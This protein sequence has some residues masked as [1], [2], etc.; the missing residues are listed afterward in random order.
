MEWVN[1]PDVVDALTGAPID[2]SKS[3]WVCMT[4]MCRYQ[5]D[6]MA[7]IRE[8]NAGACISCGSM[9]FQTEEQEMTNEQ[10]IAEMDAQSD[11]ELLENDP[12]YK[13]Y[14]DRM[15]RRTAFVIMS[16]YNLSEGDRSDE[17]LESIKDGFRDDFLDR[18][19]FVN[20]ACPTVYASV[21]RVLGWDDPVETTN[22]FGHISQ[23]LFAIQEFVKD[24]INRTYSYVL[25][26]PEEPKRYDLPVVMPLGDTDGDF[27]HMME[28][29]LERPTIK[30]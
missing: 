21:G 20:V 1:Q 23:A 8:E 7:A 26:V 3:T 10:K 24:N 14:L 27:M 18:V 25:V 9:E 19:E 6:S 16:E 12:G 2:K 30:Q 28:R 17:E 5:E 11:L 13:E 22:Y 4:C 29:A 15:A